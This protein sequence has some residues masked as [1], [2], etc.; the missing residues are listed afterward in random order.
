MSNTHAR[1]GGKVDD[2][3]AVGMDLEAAILGKSL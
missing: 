3:W 1:T 2:P